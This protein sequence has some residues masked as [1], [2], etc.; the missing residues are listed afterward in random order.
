MIARAAG[1]GIL[2]IRERV[3]S[4]GGSLSIMQTET[5]IRIDSL[6]PAGSLGMPA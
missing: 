6:I 5:G 1:Y 2:G 4:L 3:A